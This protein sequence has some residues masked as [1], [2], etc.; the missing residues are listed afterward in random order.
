MAP[1]L[2]DRPISAIKAYFA[3][4]G[5]P[6]TVHT[7]P[8]EQ[9]TDD[10]MR[11]LPR[12][13]RRALATSDATHWAALGQVSRHYGRGRSEEDAIRSAARRYRVEQAPEDAGSA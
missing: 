13:V 9:P 7:S 8:P 2:E 5:V 12:R 1:L 6:L 10:V 4:K 11:R 3:A